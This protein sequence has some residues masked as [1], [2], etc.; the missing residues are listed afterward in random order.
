MRFIL[1]TKKRSRNLH[2]INIGVLTLAI[3]VSFLIFGYTHYKTTYDNFHSGGDN[4]YRLVYDQYIDGKMERTKSTIHTPVGPAVQDNFPEV[5]QYAR[6]Y[7]FQYLILKYNETSQFRETNFAMVDTNFVH[8]FVPELISGSADVLADPTGI[9][10][11][12]S[13]AKKYFGNENPLGKVLR[14]S[15]M[16]PILPANVVVKGVYKD[17]PENSY[18]TYDL[19]VSEHFWA[20][21]DKDDWTGDDMA[22]TFFL[23]ADNT[24]IDNLNNKIN[25]F[26]GERT[27]KELEASGRV[28]EFHLQP[29]SDIYVVNNFEDGIT[30]EHGL[31][32]FSYFL[33]NVIGFFIL[34]GG[35]VNCVNVNLAISIENSNEFKIRKLFG[36]NMQEFMITSTV[37]T[38]TIVM[39]SAIISTILLAATMPW[40]ERHFE[41]D[42]HLASF[43][44]SGLGIT[45][46]L[47]LFGGGILPG[48]VIGVYN[49]IFNK[50]SDI[51]SVKVHLSRSAKIIS[52]VSLLFQ[53]ALSFFCLAFAFNFFIQSRLL[54]QKDL[55]FDYNNKYVFFAS[56]EAGDL[57]QWGENSKYDA[58]K[59]ELMNNANINEVNSAVDVPG[60]TIGAGSYLL[61]RM[62]NPEI[63]TRSFFNWVEPGFVNMFDLEVL[64]GD[65]FSKQDGNTLNKVI[66][67]RK[68]A[69]RLG[70]NEPEDAIGK[71]V[72]IAKN[73]TTGIARAT[74]H[75]VIE[76]FVNRSI[77]MEMASYHLIPVSYSGG[78]YTASIKPT[79]DKSEVVSQ[80]EATF[81]Q[82]FP[83][84]PFYG[85][86]HSDLVQRQTKPMND[87]SVLIFIALVVAILTMLVGLWSIAIVMIRQRMKE[88]GLRRVLGGSVNH[89]LRIFT[90]RYL[91]TLLACLVIVF[92]LT[93]MVNESFLQNLPDRIRFSVFHYLSPMLL[94]TVIVLVTVVFSVLKYATKRPVDVLR[95]D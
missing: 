33:L 43:F 58:L 47:L 24:S 37:S 22:E 64:A 76:N 55:G 17:F 69:K 32:K 38:A 3:I 57:L 67:N 39:L 77:N 79:A 4:L 78:F 81:E 12:E 87:V 84:T 27:E 86:W 48:V 19:L 42:V 13:T 80:I 29:L 25:S 56:Y 44:T 8:M 11:S 75:G 31:G 53:F 52:R 92:P 2:L 93:Y 9:L 14:T 18:F 26:I 71:S 20:D 36:A 68:C 5:R 54:T 65:V 16:Y 72:M 63:S 59:N 6:L 85:Y 66:I 51:T 83:Q 82:F 21:A 23:L 90:M 94:M 40:Y 73:H 74:I 91:Y 62:D 41:I 45:F 70:F 89:I 35:L 61:I 10:V 7:Q 49:Y 15:S 46:C 28:H 30:M 1:R 34:I 50:S 95:V 60:Y 88:V